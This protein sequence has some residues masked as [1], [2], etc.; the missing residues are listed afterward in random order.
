M[1]AQDAVLLG[2]QSRN[3]RTRTMVMPVRAELH[4]DAAHLLEGMRQQQSLRRR[5][6][7][8]SPDPFRIPGVANLETTMGWLHPAIARAA[9]DHT[10]GIAHHERHGRAGIAH[11]Q[12]LVDVVTDTVHG[13]DMGVPESPQVAIRHGRCETAGM[14]LRQGFKRDMRIR[15]ARHLAP[16]IRS[17]SG[18]RHLSLPSV[19]AVIS[20]IKVAGLSRQ[21]ATAASM[22]AKS[23]RPYQ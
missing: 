13:R 22:A 14:I 3:S 8:G 20:S 10:V 11:G 19:G 12:R 2:A 15:E 18:D 7:C 21:C 1:I 17:G 6:Q 16:G 9:D 4:R 5:I 23:S